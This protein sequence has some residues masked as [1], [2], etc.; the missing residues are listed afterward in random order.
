MP[1]IIKLENVL[2]NPVSPSSVVIR[3]RVFLKTASEK[4]GWLEVSHCFCQYNNCMVR[5]NI[6]YRFTFLLFYM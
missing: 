2:M 4:L 3:P 5:F 1:L 6:T